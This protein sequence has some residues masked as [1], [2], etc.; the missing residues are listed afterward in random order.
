[1]KDRQSRG[2]GDGRLSQSRQDDH[3]HLFEEMIFRAKSEKE[4]AM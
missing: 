2:C 3:R 4:P 1:M